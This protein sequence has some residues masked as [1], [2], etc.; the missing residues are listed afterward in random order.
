MKDI[1]DIRDIEDIEDIIDQEDVINIDLDEISEESY[2]NA[3]ELISNIEKYYYDEDFMKK[4]PKLKK[5]IDSE[6][7]SIR[8]LIKMKK[9][10]EITHDILIKAIGKNSSNASLYKA[11]TEIQKTIISIT[12]KIS[13]IINNLL[14]I[15]K[16]YQY[17]NNEN[18][19]NNSIILE[20]SDHTNENTFRGTK[21]FILNLTKS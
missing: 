13:E 3:C 19:I 17:E 1:E 11:L 9:S 14:E 8:V 10:D 4:N 18:M 21:A 6:L 12:T 2:K 7:E 16:N 20:D 5:R 15:L